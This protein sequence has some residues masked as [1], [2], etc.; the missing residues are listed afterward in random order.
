MRLKL[1]EDPRVVDYAIEALRAA[2]I[3]PRREIIRGGTDGARLCY[4]G[5]LTPNLFAGGVNFHSKLEWVPVRWMEG[6]VETI[7]QL[8]R[9]WV[10]KSTGA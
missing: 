9:V 2:G 3:E 6:A 4:M 8:A 7:V 5:L 10:E 1:D